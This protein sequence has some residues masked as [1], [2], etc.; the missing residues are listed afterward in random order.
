MLGRKHIYRKN[1]QSNY[2]MLLA[3][4]NLKLRENSIKK[5]KMLRFLYFYTRIRY[6]VI[7]S[8]SNC[9]H[10]YVWVIWRQQRHEI[11]K[12]VQFNDVKERG[13]RHDASITSKDNWHFCYINLVFFFQW[14][15]LKNKQ[16]D[17]DTQI[18][19]ITNQQVI[20]WQLNPDTN[21][22]GLARKGSW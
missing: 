9:T 19:I 17:N 13:K 10:L 16:T 21:S 12:N 7:L 3:L 11:S 2:S 1:V 15:I 6:V 22:C 8:C 20:W 14:W 18:M 4:T 5:L